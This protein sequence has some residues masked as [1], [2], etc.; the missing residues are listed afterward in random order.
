MKLK[1]AIIRKSMT[2][3]CIQFLQIFVTDQP[4]IYS[5]LWNKRGIIKIHMLQELGIP[6]SSKSLSFESKESIPPKKM[7][8][9]FSIWSLKPNRI[10]LLSMI[11]YCV[12]VTQY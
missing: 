11:W 3:Q 7:L 12:R 8:N 1:R 2:L 9:I 6:R 5:W 10:A 4:D